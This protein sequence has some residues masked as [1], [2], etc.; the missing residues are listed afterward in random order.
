VV[1]YAVCLLV[2]KAITYE[3]VVMLPKGKKIAK[4]LEKFDFLG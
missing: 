4:V 3:D 1:V 2:S